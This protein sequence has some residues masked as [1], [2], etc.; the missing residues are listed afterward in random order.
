MPARKQLPPSQRTQ[1]ED[2]IETARALESDESREAFERVFERITTAHINPH[3]SYDK[4][5]S[6][7]SA[8][9]PVSKK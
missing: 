6:R 7:R 2:F 5:S 9:A 3:F 1:S 4:D 8:K